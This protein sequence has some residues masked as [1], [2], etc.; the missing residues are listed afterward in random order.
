MNKLIKTFADQYGEE[1]QKE[2]LAR[3]EEI[4]QTAKERFP[5][6][7]YPYMAG[8]YSQLNLQLIS[9]IKTLS[10]YGKEV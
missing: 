6:N 1:Y 9:V 4:E 2:I 7:P 8:A 10:E 5:E 3:I